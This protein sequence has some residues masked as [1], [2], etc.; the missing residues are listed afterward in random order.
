MCTNFWILHQFKVLKVLDHR[1]L[2]IVAYKMHMKK[3]PSYYS[4]YLALKSFISTIH[5]YIQPNTLHTQDYSLCLL[6]DQ[7]LLQTLLS[8]PDRYHCMYIHLL[9]LLIHRLRFQIAIFVALIFAPQ[10]THQDSVHLLF[11]FF[12]FRNGTHSFALK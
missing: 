12:V 1:C 7:G 6:L 3:S 4:Q 9:N 8:N 10:L 11:F 2:T 5:V